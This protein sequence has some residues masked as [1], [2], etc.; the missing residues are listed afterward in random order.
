[1]GRNEFLNEIKDNIKHISKAADN[2]I[3]YN[4][5]ASKEELHKFNISKPY[6]IT[7]IEEIDP[8]LELEDIEQLPFYLLKKQ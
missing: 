3:P 5:C 4:L 8:K 7:I 1:M 2:N 6:L